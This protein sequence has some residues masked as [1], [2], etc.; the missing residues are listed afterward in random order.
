M[1]VG[2]LRNELAVDLER[3]RELFG[4]LVHAHHRTT[5]GDLHRLL[6]A[7]N[8]RVH[9]ALLDGRVVAAN[10]VADE[11]GLPPDLSEATRTGQARLRA[12]ALADVL[13]AHLGHGEAGPLRMRRSVRVAVHPALRRRGIAS[14]LIEHTHAEPEVD[15]F[16]TLFGASPELIEFRRRLGY[17]LVRVSASRG[18]RTGEP[19]VM[20]L[21]PVSEPAKRLVAELRREL[22]RELDLQLALLE[23][24]DEL[25]MDPA[26]IAALR[27]DLDAPVPYSAAEQS[28]CAR[29]YAEVRY[30]WWITR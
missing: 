5:P 14:R 25:P 7:P 24:D 16:G 22:A 12:H 20:M 10:L 9:A 3:L 17:V 2:G 18:A 6:D 1:W 26:L 4:L 21:R 28:A 27:R 19:S 13:V 11:G 23:A 8:L 30:V 15:L 29:A